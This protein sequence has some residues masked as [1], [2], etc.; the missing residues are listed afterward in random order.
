[1]TGARV[2]SSA[3]MRFS[4][5]RN[6]PPYYQSMELW[7]LAKFWPEPRF[8][9]GRRLS[10]AHWSFYIFPSFFTHPLPLINLIN[11]SVC[12]IIC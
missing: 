11:M 8:H 2:G 10:A 9:V 3:F 5:P 7:F 6:G 12:K 4:P 1:M